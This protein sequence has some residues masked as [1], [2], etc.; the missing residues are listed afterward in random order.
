MKSSKNSG[1]KWLVKRRIYRKKGNRAV[2]YIEKWKFKKLT[3]GN[4]IQIISEQLVK[5]R[6][7][8]N[9]QHMQSWICEGKKSK[10]WSI[11]L[12]WIYKEKNPFG[13]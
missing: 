9:T 5:R 1:K 2:G 13:F 3:K 10:Q 6:Q 8:P 12:H 7:G 11:V 4:Q